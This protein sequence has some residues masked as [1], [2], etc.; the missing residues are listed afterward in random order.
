M[1]SEYIR[2][3]VNGSVDDTSGSRIHVRVPNLTYLRAM[4]GHHVQKTGNMDV[5]YTDMELVQFESHFRNDRRVSRCGT[6]AGCRNVIVAKYK[7]QGLQQGLCDALVAVADQ[8]D[9]DDEGSEIPLGT[10]LFGL[11]K[12]ITSC[13]LRSPKFRYG[14]FDMSS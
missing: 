7:L 6:K 12:P 2:V 13:R 3:E 10:M 8:E 9:C 11:L 4:Q 5:G 1:G 14:W